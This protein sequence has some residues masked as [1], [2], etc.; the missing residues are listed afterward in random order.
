MTLSRSEPTRLT[1]PAAWGVTALWGV[2]VLGLTFHHSENPVLL[3]R[4]SFRYAALLLAALLATPFVFAAARSLFS[5]TVLT[6]PDGRRTR[7]A[8][9]AKIALILV[10]TLTAYAALQIAL[11]RSGLRV[12]RHAFL[13]LVPSPDPAMGVNRLGFRGEDPVLPKPPGHFRVVLLGGSTTFGPS[14]AYADS[15]GRRLEQLLRA[16]LSPRT[17]D[18]QSAACPAYTTAHDVVRYALD[19]ID[20]QA[21]VVLVMEAVNDLYACVGSHERFRR[22]YG[23]VAG[24]KPARWYHDRSPLVPTIEHY[25]TSVLFSDFRR[26]PNL[27]TEGIVPDP[28][29]FVRN[30]RSL[31]VLARSRGQRIVLCTQPH[32]F[33]MSLPAPDRLRGDSAL[34]NFRNG[35]ALPTFRWFCEHMA[36]FN[37]KTRELA[38]EEG[39][40]LLDFERLFPTT[41]S[42]YEDEIHMTKDGARLEAEVAERFLEL[43]ILR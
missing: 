42:L 15:Y 38:A 21:D 19:A 6:H 10:S 43:V 12:E 26:I 40:P 11:P 8:P 17:V 25:L 34:R 29:P 24:P 27:E 22:D 9:G 31:I 7:F 20:L 30:L 16:R 39:V 35:V 2:V 36:E 13:Q 5:A 3:G 14:L 4:F 33:R 23:H 28:G 32:R 1:I 37:Q 18:V 41:A